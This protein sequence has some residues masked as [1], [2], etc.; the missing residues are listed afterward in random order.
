MKK[1]V[2][3][4][5]GF[6]F[7]LVAISQRLAV[8]WVEKY[9]APEGL[10]QNLQFIKAV[11]TAEDALISIYRK[12]NAA[13][14]DN[15]Y[16]LVKM[17]AKLDAAGEIKLDYPT[18][19]NEGM[20]D[21]LK[22]KQTDYLLEYKVKGNQLAELYLTPINLKT[23]KKEISTKKIVDL[24]DNDLLA[25]NDGEKQAYSVY[26]DVVYSPDSS[27]ILLNY[28]AK[29]QEE[30]KME[31]VVL[32]NSGQ[33]LYNAIHTWED[34]AENRQMQKPYIDN[35]GKCF[36]LWRSYDKA[37]NK[38]VE[39]GEGEQ[40]PSFKSHLML[41]EKDN[42]TMYTFNCDGKYLNDMAIG[43]N[44]DKKPLVMGT[45]KDKYNG[46]INGV[47]ISPAVGAEISIGNLVFTPYHDGLQKKIEL[48]LE[49]KPGKQGLTNEYYVGSTISAAEGVNYMVSEYFKQGNSEN[50]AFYE[51]GDIVVTT[52]EN[53]GNVVFQ[54]LPRR[55]SIA[56]S[57]TG[58]E[59]LAPNELV[60]MIV[61]NKMVVLYGDNEENGMQ[62]LKE[63]PIRF[64]KTN[65]SVVLAAA[66]NN[67]GKLLSRKIIFNHLDLEGYIYNYK[68][69]PFRI[70]TYAIFATKP[71]EAKDGMLMGLLNAK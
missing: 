56:A 44:K 58:N 65:K 11:P 32:S 47:F 41:V 30:N 34:A 9:K 45:Y 18:N 48:D 46:R 33:V 29:F 21:I 22:M 5:V 67:V 59:Y 36:I 42:K 24:V 54:C 60:T 15:D 17:N 52:F 20:I 27:K 25:K 1:L 4:A 8:R 28:Y 71:N 23:F 31:S 10:Y 14:Y 66:F 68:L 35:D 64:Y 38:E 16:V 63:K 40:I 70:N 2:S 50:A 3:L 51:K 69:C 57:L 61:D 43:F 39:K 53:D 19:G 13:V 7:S 6:L 12:M 37:F 26:L 62:D 55:Q 49:L